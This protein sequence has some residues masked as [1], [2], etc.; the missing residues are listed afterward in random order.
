MKCDEGLSYLR[1]AE[2]C[3]DEIR[4][5]YTLLGDLKG[6]EMHFGL[7]KGFDDANIYR[8]AMIL[9]GLSGGADPAWRDKEMWRWIQKAKARSL[10]EFMGIGYRTTARM[11]QQLS[12][13]Q[14][15]QALLQK[16]REFVHK[17]R[18]VYITDAPAVR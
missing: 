17:A 2:K 7:S 8:E 9:L 10:S 18:D 16:E 15:Y 5:D 13:F 14:K 12:S 6:L 4:Q 3:C 11:A 1:E